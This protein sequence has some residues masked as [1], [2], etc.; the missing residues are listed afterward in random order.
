MPEQHDEWE[1]ALP[2]S[3]AA[4]RSCAQCGR[5]FPARNNRGYCSNDCQIQA[6]TERKRYRRQQARLA[7][8]A[9][10]E[11]EVRRLQSEIAD[12]RLLLQ[13]RPTRIE[14]QAAANGDD[15]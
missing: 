9:E 4:S 14:R 12:L 10:L 13:R 2:R 11:A 6:G 5:Q 8:L 1:L 7:R 3:I 15:R